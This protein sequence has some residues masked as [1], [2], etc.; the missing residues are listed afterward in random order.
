ML[1]ARQL[2][3]QHLRSGVSANRQP[4]P[5]SG[6]ADPNGISGAS[7]YMRGIARPD[8][9]TLGPDGNRARDL[10]AIATRSRLNFAGRN[11]T[12]PLGSSET[13]FYL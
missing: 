11:P 6:R 3:E 13:G 2:I 4:A 10:G 8:R 1:N 12:A 5:L 9:S 7:E